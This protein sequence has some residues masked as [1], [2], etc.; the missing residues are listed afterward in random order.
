MI[1]FDF[2][3]LKGVDKTFQVGIIKSCGAWDVTKHNPRSKG[4]LRW[5]ATTK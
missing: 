2:F 1:I 4:A 3:F 5:K